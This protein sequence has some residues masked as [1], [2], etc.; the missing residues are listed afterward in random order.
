ME[1][2][3]KI[4]T[5][6]NAHGRGRKAWWA[7][8]LGIPPLTLSHWLARRQSPSGTHA[9]A[10]WEILE[11][12]RQSQLARTLLDRLWRVHYNGEKIPSVLLPTIIDEIIS[13][14]ILDSRSWALVSLFVGST[15]DVSWEI[16]TEP[17]VRNRLGWLLAVSGTKAPWKVVGNVEPQ[18]ISPQLG[19]AGKYFW[20]LQ[21][22]NGRRWRI[23]D[24]PLDEMKK[25]LRVKR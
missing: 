11:K 12:Q 20:K 5:D 2:V 24:F 18:C 25:L 22:G 1:I 3:Q 8:R 13:C 10:I 19:A 15:K 16:P 23:L 7:N 6:C 14:P 21:T 4:Q 9:L 17:A